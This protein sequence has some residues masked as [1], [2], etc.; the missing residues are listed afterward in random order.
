[1]LGSYRAGGPGTAKVPISEFED[2]QFFGPIAVGTPPQAFNVIFD[3]GSSNL[4]V[5]SKNCSLLACGLHARYDSTKSSTYV[6]NGTAFAIDYASGPVSGWLEGDVVSVG[7]IGVPAYTFAE[8]DN[9]TGLGPAFLLGSFDGI[10]GMGF[11]SIS[12]DGLPTVFGA[13][14]AAGLLSEPVFGFYFDSTGNNGEL[15]L[16]GI[17]PSHYSGTLAMVPLSKESYWEI[18]GLQVLVGGTSASKVSRAVFDTGTSLL[19]GPVAD[20]AAIAKQLGA[21]PFINPNEYTLPCSSLPSLPNV[22]FVIAGLPY[23]LTPAQYVIEVEG[24]E[25]LLG[26]TGIDIPA[27]AGPLWIIGDIFQRAYYTAYYWSSPQQVG[28]APIVN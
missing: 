20:V 1:M 18:T 11:R 6:P 8:I 25:C 16:G 21:T 2:A 5:P 7:G 23:T 19:A 10:L 17:D 13:M 3:T 26:F 14:E 22:T 9:P 27:P 12:V 4:W 15:E 24:I 28:L